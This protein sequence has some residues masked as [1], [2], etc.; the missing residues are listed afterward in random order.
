MI[1]AESWRNLSDHGG[2]LSKKLFS[3]LQAGLDEFLIRQ[4]E[5]KLSGTLALILPNKNITKQITLSSCESQ[6]VAPPIGFLLL[7]SIRSGYV[8]RL[9]DSSRP[10]K[11]C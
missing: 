2:M 3:S 1:L 7:G 11:D 4:G 6:S 9:K 10:K 5:T 8:S